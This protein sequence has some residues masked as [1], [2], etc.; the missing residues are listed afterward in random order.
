MTTR[1]ETQVTEIG[2][3]HDAG[4]GADDDLLDVPPPKRLSRVT[5]V[6]VAGIVAAAGFAGGA[7]VQK[8]HD[9]GLTSAGGAAGAFR[10]QGTG[11]GTGGAEGFPGGGFPVGG[12]GAGGSGAAAPA[13]VGRVVSVSGNT[14]TVKNFA[15]RTVTVTVPEGTSVTSVVPLSSLKAG[16]SVS[17]TGTAGADGSV[18]ASGVTAR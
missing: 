12:T 14:L 17:V 13:V 2:P 18:T 8:H 15:G 16:T 9:A 10:R 1:P 11:T 3:D 6:L 5:A 4:Y 7:L